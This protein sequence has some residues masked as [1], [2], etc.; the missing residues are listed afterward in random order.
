LETLRRLRGRNAS[1]STKP[2]GQVKTVIVAGI[3]LSTPRRSASRA[4]KTADIPIS[5]GIKANGKTINKS[6]HI[7]AI[8]DLDVKSRNLPAAQL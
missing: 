8:S 1:Q 3:Y 5:T 2:N 7:M 6:V 4:T